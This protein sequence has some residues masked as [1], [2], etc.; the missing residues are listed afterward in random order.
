MWFCLLFFNSLFR[1]FCLVLFRLCLIFF[2]LY[3][4]LLNQ[5]KLKAKRQKKVI[6]IFI[7]G[8]SRNTTRQISI[9]PRSLSLNFQ[10]TGNMWSG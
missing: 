8:R 10:R 6:F 5:I 2:R 7:F 4:D 1:S 3:F 9:H